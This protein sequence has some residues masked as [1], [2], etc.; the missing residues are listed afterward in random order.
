MSEIYEALTGTID[1]VNVI[2]TTS[3]TPEFGTL[4][5]FDDMVEVTVSS[6]TG[7]TITLALPPAAGSQL[8]AVY[9]V[10]PYEE[11]A[12]DL[13]VDALAEIGVASIEDKERIDIA[14]LNLAAL[15][16]CVHRYRLPPLACHLDLS[17]GVTSLPN[18]R[19]SELEI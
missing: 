15:L 2:F 14:D 10:K 5:V 11:T 19:I 6:Y 3:Q 12:L 8:F 4:H 1:G 18:K 13:I 9:R 7:T 16:V 17:Q